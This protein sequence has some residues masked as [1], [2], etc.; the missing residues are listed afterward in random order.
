MVLGRVSLYIR[1][2]SESRLQ[3]CVYGSWLSPISS[4]I[5]TEGSVAFQEVHVDI[6]SKT[7][8]ELFYRS[9]AV[10]KIV[11]DV[12]QNDVVC[13]DIFVLHIIDPKIMKVISERSLK[14]NKRF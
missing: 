8:G 12:S 1:N 9:E 14:E 5:A 3:Q 10:C 4:K 6:F 7:P 11:R 2:M 13:S